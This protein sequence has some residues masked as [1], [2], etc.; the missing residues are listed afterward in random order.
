MNEELKAKFCHN[1]W[2]LGRDIK[3]S[4]RLKN[5]VTTQKF[6]VATQSNAE[7][8]NSVATKNLLSRHTIQVFNMQGIQELSRHCQ[9]MSQENSRREHKNVATKTACH[10][11]MLGD[12]DENY[13]ATEL[14]ISQQ[15][16]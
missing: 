5:S 14:S 6:Y 7:E 3:E 4:R 1:N 10:D 13:V 9:L 2:K 16:Y 8:G 15:S 12:R 11:K